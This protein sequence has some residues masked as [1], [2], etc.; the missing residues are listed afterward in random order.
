MHNNLESFLLDGY[1]VSLTPETDTATP[2]T[3]V[4]IYSI[5][6]GDTP[7]CKTSTCF[8]QRGK[9]AAAD[10]YH[11]IH[12]GRLQ[13]AYVAEQTEFTLHFLTGEPQDRHLHGHSWEQT[14]NPDVKVCTLCHLRGYCPGCSPFP[15]P[16]AMPFHCTLHTDR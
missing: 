6:N 4:P 14:Q 2:R 16:G 9:R 3:P 15:P 8:C 12:N 10:L 1:P 5:H 11:E 13:L 7:F